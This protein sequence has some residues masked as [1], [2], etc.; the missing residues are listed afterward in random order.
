[1][2]RSGVDAVL[3]GNYF[4]DIVLVRRIAGL[5]ADAD[6]VAVHQQVVPEVRVAH[7]DAVWRPGLVRQSLAARINSGWLQ[8]RQL[9][10]IP[11]ETRVSFAIFV[12]MMSSLFVELNS[13]AGGVASTVTVCWRVPGLRDAF[14]VTSPPDCTITF[15]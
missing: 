11:V 12:S 10:R 15:C 2:T 14:T 6:R 9:E 8:Q 3:G 5:V 13:T 4:L 1:M 7:I